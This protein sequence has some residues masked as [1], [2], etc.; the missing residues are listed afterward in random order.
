MKSTDSLRAYTL[1]VYRHAKDVYSGISLL[2]AIAAFLTAVAASVVPPQWG[3]SA[4]WVER[5]AGIGGVFLLLCYTR[6]AFL[7]WREA[8]DSSPLASSPDVRIEAVS[9]RFE[10][11][12]LARFPKGDI[13]FHV[14]LD[15]RNARPEPVDIEDLRVEKL[16]GASFLGEVDAAIYLYKSW[17]LSGHIGKKLRL[18][19][20]S[21]RWDLGVWIPTPL[22]VA[23]EESFAREVANLADFAVTLRFE[24]EYLSGDR[25]SVLVSSAGSFSQFRNGLLEKWRQS[26][27][28]L[29]EIAGSAADQRH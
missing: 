1:S 21:R 19:P 28:D 12:M 6:A 11:P 17:K 15:V 29:W 25:R 7:A 2:L 14:M 16:Q 26:A 24:L 9:A 4:E 8:L 13:G 18:E 3:L 5:S 10:A 22:V 27:P 23:S 20:S